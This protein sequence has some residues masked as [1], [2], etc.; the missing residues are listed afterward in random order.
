MI[1]KIKLILRQTIKFIYEFSYNIVVMMVTYIFIGACF[2]V[3]TRTM[4]FANVQKSN[5]HLISSIGVM[6]M[7]S[8]YF[9]N[10][11][12]QT[13]IF[14]GTLRTKLMDNNA[15]NDISYVLCHTFIAVNGEK[16]DVRLSKME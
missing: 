9:G 3:L 7:F 5:T 16:Q 14:I 11:L 8:V 2:M 15:M 10:V 13:E 1:I 12:R 6:W 4:I